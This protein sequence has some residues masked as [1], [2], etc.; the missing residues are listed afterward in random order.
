MSHEALY[1]FKLFSV[2]RIKLCACNLKTTSP[3]TNSMKA[4]FY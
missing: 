2:R 3:G 4:V 1:I